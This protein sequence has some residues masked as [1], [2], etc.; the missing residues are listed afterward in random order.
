MYEFVEIVK[1]HVDGHD[2]V[3]ISARMVPSEFFALLRALE[4]RREGRP[5]TQRAFDR[6]FAEGVKAFPELQTLVD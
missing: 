2:Y 6:L 1:E 5:V 4:A 3:S